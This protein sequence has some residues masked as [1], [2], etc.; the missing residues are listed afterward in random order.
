MA[1]LIVERQPNNDR[2]PTTTFTLS[3]ERGKQIRAIAAQHHISI[4]ELI[5]KFINIEIRKGT[6]RDEIPGYQIRRKGN[7]VQFGVGKAIIAI[8]PEEALGFSNKLR[9]IACEPSFPPS[10]R[11]R[12]RKSEYAFYGLNYVENSQL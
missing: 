7:V 5:A 9:E 10:S 11:I 2:R 4:A 3:T 12:D 1:K 6:I 8:T